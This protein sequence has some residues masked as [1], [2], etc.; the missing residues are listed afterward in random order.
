MARTIRLAGGAQG[1]N[2]LPV[3]V[4]EQEGLFAEHGLEI[5][6]LRM[7]SVDKATAA[8]RDG[9]A[10]LAITP[11]EGAIVDSLAGGPLRI[12]GSN[13]ERLPMSMVARAGISTLADL[14]GARIGTSSL[15]EGTAIY[16]RAML[17]AVDL[18]YPGDY[19]FVL[20]GVH[21]ARW[22]ALENGDIDA[23]PQPA[24]WNFLAQE[25]GYE[26]VGEVSDAIPS[27]IFAALI[28]SEGWIDRNPEVLERLLAVL[29]QA[30]AVV[31]DPAN[32][33]ITRPI[34][35]R[36]TTPDHPELARRGLDYTRGLGMWPAGLQVSP[37]AL[38]ATIDVM[39]RAGL[40]AEDRRADARNAVVPRPAGEQ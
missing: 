9:E 19:E 21:T 28:A 10:D 7:G 25:R 13:S 35:Q 29:S 6:Y 26:L 5:D 16:T 34:Y 1:F 18:H 12:V 33:E 20:S 8:V 32:D 15:T 22:A 11:P 37:D 27:I 30:H 14:R 17:E 31:N 3:F 40:I 36:I 24:P 39:L 38:D 4:A 23:A 2:W